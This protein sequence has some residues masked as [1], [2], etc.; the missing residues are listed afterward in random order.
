MHRVF[1]VSA[2]LSMTILSTLPAR[3]ATG[4]DKPTT[5]PSSNPAK[6]PMSITLTTPAFKPGERIPRDNTGYGE[7]KSPRL[8]WS[9]PP[10][11]T[12]EL[13]IV[14]DDPDVKRPGGFVHWVIYKIP[15]NTRSLPEALTRDEKPAEPAG[16]VQGR[17]DFRKIGYYGPLTPPGPPHHYTFR[18]F[19]LDTVIDLPAGA[20]KKQ[21]MEKIEGHV[22]AGGELV[23]LFQKPE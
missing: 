10:D 18:I 14:F 4:D 11:G 17:N 12:K 5:Q 1:L 21:L 2:V 7:D 19:A 22:L 15:P 6:Y 20:T 3:R 9:A 16:A 23:G 13:A 8:E